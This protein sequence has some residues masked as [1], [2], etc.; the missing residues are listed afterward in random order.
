MII[1]RC[2]V[3]NPDQRPIFV[4]HRKKNLEYRRKFVHQPMKKIG[5]R[6][7]LLGFTLVTIAWLLKFSNWFLEK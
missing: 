4:H 1:I 6:L 2:S 3:K 5:D 7:I